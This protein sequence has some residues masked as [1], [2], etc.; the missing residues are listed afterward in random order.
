MRRARPERGARTP[1]DGGPIVWPAAGLVAALAFLALLLAAPPA[2]NDVWAV[3][4]FRSLDFGPRFAL[5]L[6]A[7]G[8]ACLPFVPRRRGLAAALGVAAAI[9]IAFALRERVHFLGDTQIRQRAMSA[10]SV[11]LVQVSI[12]EWSTRMHAN[13]LDI[14]VDFLA[15]IALLRMGASL[16][17]AVS[18]VSFLLALAFFAGVWRVS[19][20]LGAPPG[21][22]LALAAALALAGSLETFAG[23]AES[24][25]LLLVAAAWWWAEM[26][27][28]LTGRG[29][30]LR[31]A[32][33]WLAL[34]MAHRIGVIMLLPLAWRALGPPLAGD[35][36][37]GRRWLAGAGAAAAAIAAATLL[38][39]V[40]GRQLGMDAHDLLPSLGTMAKAVPP[41]DLINILLLVMPFALLAPWLAGRDPVAAFA[42]SAEGRL[43]L[44]AAAPLVP[45]IWIVPSGANALG[46]HRDW[47]LGTFAGLTLTIAASLLVARLPAPRLRG[48]L[49]VALPVAALVAGGWVTVNADNDAMTPRIRAL[50]LDPPGLIAPQQSHLHMYMGQRAMDLGAPEFAAPEFDRA[51]ALNPNPRRA[52][53]AAEAWARAGRVVSARASL[54]RARAAGPLSPS[55]EDGAKKVATLIDRVAADS[56]AADSA[57]A[58]GAPRR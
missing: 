10:F 9:V 47:D 46:A 24:G 22:R 45:L 4:A 34:F 53:L 11:N 39:G 15:P 50:A 36:P 17:D 54:A 56:V 25:G 20:R 57:R 8:A 44:V 3:N 7:T 33:A 16:A 21:L 52:L 41:S 6:L 48:A 40:G 19:G 5:L 14:L 2:S 51:F 49:I 37:E 31:T 55:L 43:V 27:A 29:Q 26:L 1:H 28:P 35:A 13:P 23:Y 38:I 58:A 32:L 12:A 42:R 18:V 30:A